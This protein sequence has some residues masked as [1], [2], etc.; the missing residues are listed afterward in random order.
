MQGGTIQSLTLKINGFL[1]LPQTFHY[2]SFSNSGKTFF[3]RLPLAN[4]DFSI[5]P[6]NLW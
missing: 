1:V 3:L 2:Q 5:V 6:I 4:A